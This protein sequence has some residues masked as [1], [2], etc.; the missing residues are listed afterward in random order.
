MC[1]KI[2]HWGYFFVAML[3]IATGP[4]RAEIPL[5]VICE[6][7]SGVRLCNVDNIA[8]GP[9]R[10]EIPLGVICDRKQNFCVTDRDVSD[11]TSRWC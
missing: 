3:N 9:G 5:G 6:S 1:H 2:A 4:V 11:I 7:I 10:A 8:T